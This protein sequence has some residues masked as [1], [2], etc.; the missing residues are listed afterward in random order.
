MALP[1]PICGAQ[2]AHRRQPTADVHRSARAA[3]RPAEAAARSCSVE[4]TAAKTEQMMHRDPLENPQPLIRRVYSYV[5]Y[6]IGEGADAEDVTSA[7]FERALR[8]RHTFDRNRGEPISWLIGI[9]ARCVSDH[10]AH[11]SELL[12][13]VPETAA[14]GDI[15]TDAAGRID[16]QRAVAS[17]DRRDRELVALRYGADLTARQIGDLLGMRTNA[18][19][20]ALHRMLGALRDELERPAQGS[21]AAEPKRELRATE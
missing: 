14:L 12:G 13:E 4:A 6:R 20:V 3:E 1:W 7:A 21:H 11:R 8:Y 10:L 9:A 18:V 19:E 2:F 17:L 5:A 15:A 16:L